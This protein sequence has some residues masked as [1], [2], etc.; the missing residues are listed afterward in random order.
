ML[1][2]SNIAN[3]AEF[4]AFFVLTRCAVAQD[5]A[6]RQPILGTLPRCHPTIVLRPTHPRGSGARDMSELEGWKLSLRQISRRK[7]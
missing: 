2:S 4:D 5:R 6:P 7:G 3:A 1:G